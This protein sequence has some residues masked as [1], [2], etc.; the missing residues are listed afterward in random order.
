MQAPSY[1]K[2]NKPLSGIAKV[3]IL[4][5]PLL[6]ITVFA[7]FFTGI[8]ITLLI[9]LLIALILNPAVDYLESLG[10]NR[11]LSILII[12]L[13]IGIF[14]YSILS[15]FLP[16]I[17]GQID[18]LKIAY[19][20]LEV[21]D[22]VRDWERWLEKNVPYLKRGDV[23]KEIE[24]SFKG[25]Y[26]KLQDLLSSIVSLVLL[27]IIIPFITFFILKDRKAIKNGFI[28]LVPN[29]YFEMTVNIVDKIEKQLSIYVRGWIFDAFFVGTLSITGLSILGI[30]NAFLI[31]SVA[32][33]GHLIPYAG[34]VIGAVPAILISVIQFGDASMVIPIIIMFTIIY[35]LDSSAAQPFI[36]SKSADM[37]PITVIAVLLV[38]NELLGA[39]GALIAIPVATIL[40]VSA[41]ET[42]NGFRNF[43]LGYY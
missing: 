22:K 16:S 14:V 2:A 24:N 12:F 21:S 34:P 10:I 1:T 17:S 35:L 3:F 8:F 6:I 33:L 36:F 40:K 15:I 41:R 43:K 19:K 28:S 23:A 4:L 20:E 11:T 37:N 38:G 42:I 31:G 32:G 5:I 18:S 25:S 26:T 39:F 30:N 9:C 13:L 7:T 27:I 29:R